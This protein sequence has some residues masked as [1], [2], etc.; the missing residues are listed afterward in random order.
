[1]PLSTSRSLHWYYRHKESSEKKPGDLRTLGPGEQHGGA[2]SVL[3]FC[4]MH[5]RRGAGEAS[6]REVPTGQKTALHPELALLHQRVRKK[7]LTKTQEPPRSFPCK[8]TWKVHPSPLPGCCEAPQPPTVM[9]SE[10]ATRRAGTFISAGY[11][12]Y[13]L[14]HP[15]VLS[16]EAMA[17]LPPS[18]AAGGWHSLPSSTAWHPW[19][20]SGRV[21]TFAVA[22]RWL[23]HPH[24]L[25]GLWRS[26]A[27]SKEECP[28]LPGIRVSMGTPMGSQT[29]H[30]HLSLIKAPLIYV[31]IDGAQMERW[32]IPSPNSTKV[33]SPSPAGGMPAKTSQN[34]RF[35]SHT[36]SHNTP[37][38]QIAIEKSLIWKKQN[39]SKQI[40]T[41]NQMLKLRWQWC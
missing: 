38:D 1:M 31:C 27:V 8:V 33:S 18:P 2:L 21:K 40:K 25:Y 35:Q 16:G 17:G 5:P 24:V 37:N 34:R 6:N 30:P 20:T 39:I 4:L 28:P 26:Y 41:Q 19:R 13:R 12:W 10:K 9:A 32:I 36:E 23:G 15:G 14:P 22:Q 7:Q 3:S 11:R 29:C